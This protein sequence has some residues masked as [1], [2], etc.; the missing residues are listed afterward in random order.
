M[1]TW[2]KQY[3]ASASKTIPGVE[4]LY[5]WLSNNV[6]PI[7]E[8]VTLVHGDFRIDNLIFHPSEVL[9]KEQKWLYIHTTANLI[10]TPVLT[11]SC[12]YPIN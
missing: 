4:D 7:D 5:D 12:S 11:P 8:Q 10:G 2:I 6:P 3:R 1:S 9:L